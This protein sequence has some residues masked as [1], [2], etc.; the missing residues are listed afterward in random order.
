MQLVEAVLDV[1]VFIVVDLGVQIDN[2]VQDQAISS[3]SNM[4]KLKTC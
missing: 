2:V 1:G 3:E 4:E